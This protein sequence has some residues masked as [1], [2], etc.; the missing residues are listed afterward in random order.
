[1]SRSRE[2]DEDLTEIWVYV[3]A[4]NPPAA[5]RI[6]YALLDAE[7]R[8]AVFPESGR[9]RDDLQPGMR[10]WVVGS[11]VVFYRVTLDA[12]KSSVSCTA[13]ATSAT[14]VASSSA[15][16]RASAKQPVA[17]SDVK[18][19][20]QRGANCNPDYVVDAQGVKRYKK[21]CLR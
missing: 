14:A 4:D 12:L 9:S 10:A 19:P 5:D 20:P 15:S 21:E 1:M 2:A 8:L 13:P 16:T 11:Y 18:A 3:A 17:T 6:I 7:R